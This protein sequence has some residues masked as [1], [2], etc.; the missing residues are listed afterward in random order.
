MLNSVIYK[1]FAILCWATCAIIGFIAL[2]FGLEIGR[3]GF[4]LWNNFERLDAYQ[5]GEYSAMGFGTMIGFV[6]TFL[7]ARFLFQKGKWFWEY[8]EFK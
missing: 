7:G 4:I 2:R 5:Q 3:L 1:F 8:A 6:L